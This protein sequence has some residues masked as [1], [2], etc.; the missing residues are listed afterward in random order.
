MNDR[1][2]FAFQSL[3]ECCNDNQFWAESAKLVYLTFILRTGIPTRIGGSQRR[4][5][6]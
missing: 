6:R 3:K 1:P 5:A 4:W 2:T